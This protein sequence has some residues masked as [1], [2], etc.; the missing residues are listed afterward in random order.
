MYCILVYSLRAARPSS[1]NKKSRIYTCFSV[2]VISGSLLTPRSLRLSPRAEYEW[3]SRLPYRAGQMS[4]QDWPWQPSL[5]MI[6]TVMA[7]L[8]W[9]TGFARSAASGFL[10]NKDLD[11]RWLRVRIF[12]W[13]KG[14]ASGGRHKE[15]AGLTAWKI[16]LDSIIEWINQKAVCW[17]ALATSGMLNIMLCDILDTQF[18][19]NI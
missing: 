17:T 16:V 10:V 8:S 14:A 15:K 19:F 4:A 5:Q 11:L 12:W 2:K 1:S 18:A 13:E 6:T 9:K 7:E 3:P